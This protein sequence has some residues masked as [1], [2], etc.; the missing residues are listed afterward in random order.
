MRASIIDV[1][2]LEGP[3]T[4]LALDYRVEPGNKRRRLDANASFQLSLTIFLTLS[5]F[6]FVGLKELQSS[7]HAGTI[8]TVK[9]QDFSERIAMTR[10][11]TPWES[12]RGSDGPSCSF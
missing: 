12:G 10:L 9:L 6:L 3:Q 4:G 8:I 5:C 1:L 2:N 11:L 7:E